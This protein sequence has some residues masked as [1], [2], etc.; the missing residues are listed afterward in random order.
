MDKSKPHFVNN[1]VFRFTI[2]L[3]KASQNRL[4]NE[5]EISDFRKWKTDFLK[6]IESNYKKAP[7]FNF[8]NGWLINFF[9]YREYS[10]IGELAM[11]SIKSISAL[12][13]ISTQFMKSSDLAYRSFRL[14]KWSG[15][16]N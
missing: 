16:D 11:E 7:C 3:I 4:I 12:L 5:I 1:E 10:S 9:N 14:S 8:F 6:I 13:D 2:S 15:K